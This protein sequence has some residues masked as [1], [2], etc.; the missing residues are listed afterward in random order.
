MKRFLNLLLPTVFCSVIA[1][2]LPAPEAGD[3]I[4]ITSS[5]TSTLGQGQFSVHYQGSALGTIRLN[6]QGGYSI[7]GEQGNY[8]YGGSGFTFTTGPLQ[9]W[10]VIYETYSD[11]VQL[12]LAATA[13]QAAAT[14]MAIN[15]HMCRL[16]TTAAVAAAAAATAPNGDYMGTLTLRRDGMIVDIDVATG[17]VTPRFSGSDPSRAVSGETV[18]YNNGLVIVDK[19][20]V[21]VARLPT[22]AGDDPSQPIFSPDGS[23][24]AYTAMPVYYDSSVVVL[25]RKGDQVASFENMV[26]PAWTPDGRLVTAAN[27]EYEGAEPGLFISDPGLTTLTR[28]DPNLD[29]VDLPAVSPDGHTVAFSFHGQVWLM[30]LDGGNLRQLTSFN[31]RV[32]GLS[33]SPGGDA[34]AVIDGDYDEVVFVSLDG[35]VLEL[36]DDDGK[37]VQTRG[38][39]T[40]R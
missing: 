2:T 18:F 14:E 19:E 36:S 15:E 29:D 35:E 27:A 28:F 9:S 6:G 30:E 10:P 20:G 16:P 24:V 40:W 8:V 11:G 7:N 13:D 22:E 21:T 5:Y 3:Y 26:S 39:V 32:E 34:L 1:Q 25:N 23:L 33:W 17:E 37:S 12:R 31:D 38:R 4:C